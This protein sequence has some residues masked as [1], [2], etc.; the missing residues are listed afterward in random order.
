M[1]KLT[2]WQRMNTVIVQWN[3]K[4]VK[5][6]LQLLGYKMKSNVQAI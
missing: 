1:E 2:H 4:E 6:S 5:R 3:S